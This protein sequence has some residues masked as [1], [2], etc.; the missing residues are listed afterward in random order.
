M[1]G[2][3]E[4]SLGRL[5]RERETGVERSH[6]KKTARSHF[7]LIFLSLFFL[8]R[9]CKWEAHVWH[10]KKQVYLGGFDWEEHAAKA[11]DIMT[12]KVKGPGAEV[13]VDREREERGRSPFTY[14]DPRPTSS[15][16]PP[17]SFPPFTAQLPRLHLR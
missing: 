2:V 5:G 4:G 12:L 14:L 1:S 10:S 16:H 13:R 11:H 15:L 8:R 7:P 3:S 9:T 6:S 17:L